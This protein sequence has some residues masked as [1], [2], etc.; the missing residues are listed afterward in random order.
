MQ[1]QTVYTHRTCNQACLWCTVRRTSDDPAFSNTAAVLARIDAALA[2]GA[3]QIVLTGGEPGTRPDLAQLIS[4]AHQK[5]RIEVI[6]ETNGTDFDDAAARAVHSAGLSLVRL[7][8]SAADAALDAL[9]R[10]PGGSARAWTGLR[11][12]LG[13]GLIVELS[14]AIVEATRDLVLAIPQA[15]EDAGI[16]RSIRAIVCRVPTEAP[17]AGVCCKPADAARTIAA[18]DAAARR[19]NIPLALDADFAPPPCVFDHAFSVSHL[20]RLSLVH[21]QRA[22]FVQIPACAGCL[23]ND[24]CPGFAR[25][26]LLRGRPPVKPVQN[27]A[28]R[29]RLVMTR[30]PQAQA[31][32]EFSQT[33]FIPGEAN[34]EHERLIR[35]NFQC[36][37]SCRFCFVHTNLPSVD[38]AKIRAEIADA[39]AMGH[40]VVL[41]GG[42][43][44]LNP[45]LPDYVALTRQLTGKP[46]RLQTNATLLDDEAWCEQVVT[47]GVGVAQVS[48]HAAEAALSDA[49]TG[50]PGTFV[51]TVH[52]LDN[53]ANRGV[54][55]VIMFVLTSRNVRALTDLVQLIHDRWPAAALT[56]SVVTHSTE[57]VPRDATTMPQ[58]SAVAEDLAKAWELA[59]AL[60]VDI[61]GI[62]S[63]AGIP[64]CGLPKVVA[65]SLA[66]SL[67]PEDAGG[68]DF[69]RPPAC[70]GCAM[71]GYCLGVRT[72]YLA[73]YGDGEVRPFTEA[74][75]QE[76]RDR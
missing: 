72:G 15:L 5:G 41:T 42:E 33:S 9:T 11:A 68:Q 71:R 21:G 48:L 2:A 37:Q 74:F 47:A 73:L 16:A 40:R 6:L 57:I 63:K 20:F 19:F 29:R 7:N 45:K 69:V 50:A 55:L 25:S 43:P 36:N 30:D 34:F 64:L 70:T 27:D 52:G 23:L 60:N 65:R 51:R 44:T 75:V 24:R 38:D 76:Q 4:R 58:W 10:D 13:A 3:T 32:R 14:V 66:L 59:H 28:L 56:V 62:H 1:T 35:I 39:V 53:L 18:L 54:K 12:L 22:G 31:A 26:V 67:I 8:L 17:T 61:G 49:I 46:V